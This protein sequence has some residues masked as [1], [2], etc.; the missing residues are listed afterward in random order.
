MQRPHWEQSLNRTRKKQFE[1]RP[2]LRPHQAT[3]KYTKKIFCSQTSVFIV[4]NKKSPQALFYRL[5]EDFFKRALR[6]TRTPDPFITSKG[7]NCV[8]T[9]VSS[10]ASTPSATPDTNQY[11]LKKRDSQFCLSRSIITR[12]NGI[13][14]LY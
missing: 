1:C 5:C 6:G 12:T 10:S 7:K 3:P 14:S 13:C 2:H 9:K 11:T 4:R 8:F